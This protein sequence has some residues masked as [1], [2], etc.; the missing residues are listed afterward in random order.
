MRPNRYLN[1]LLIALAL[2]ALAAPATAHRPHRGPGGAGP[3]EGGF[4][5][6]GPEARLERLAMRLDL[7]DAQR[8][9]LTQLMEQSR[10]EMEASGTRERLL[11]ARRELGR[12]IEQGPFDEAAVRAAAAAVAAAEADLAVAR[13]R[14]AQAV[15]EILTPE[16]L[17]QL[18][19]LRSE[20]RER[21]M[22]RRL[23]LR[24]RRPEPR[25]GAPGVD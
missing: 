12:L 17:D 4:G 9:E 11:T 18:G 19:E 8:G 6:P 15:R 24:E 2:A 23:H 22:H 3:G 5:P 16:Q 25:A 1:R 7:S 14:R 20:R 13:A 21:R 10:A